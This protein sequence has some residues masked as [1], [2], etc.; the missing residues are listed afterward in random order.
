[1]KPSPEFEVKIDK[2]IEE[3]LNIVRDELIKRYGQKD[4][5]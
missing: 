3:V 2:C 5:K 1:V 4:T